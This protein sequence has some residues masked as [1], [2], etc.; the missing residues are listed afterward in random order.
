VYAVRMAPVLAANVLALMRGEAPRAI[1]T[2]QRD[3]LALLSTGD[4]R[5]VLRWRGFALESRWADRMKTWIDTAY[6][7]RYRTLPT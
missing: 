4:G 7:S 5:A 6:L 2:P 1:Y 3:F